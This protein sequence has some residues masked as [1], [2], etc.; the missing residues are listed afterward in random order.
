MESSNWETNVVPQFWLNMEPTRKRKEE[1]DVN[2][3]SMTSI[4]P[5][6]ISDWYYSSSPSSR[7]HSRVMHT[8]DKWTRWTTDSR[9][10]FGFFSSFTH[11]VNDDKLAKSNVK[12]NE[13]ENECDGENDND[14]RMCRCL[15]VFFSTWNCPDRRKQRRKMLI[16]IDNVFE[17]ETQRKKE[18]NN[19]W[20]VCQQDE[21]RV[22]LEL[23]FC[24]QKAYTHT[25]RIIVEL[26]RMRSERKSA[27][28]HLF[29][30]LI[31]NNVEKRRKN[32]S[33]IINNDDVKII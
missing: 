5:Q 27:R 11:C 3:C 25:C 1:K 14:D 12:E 8:F 19:Q 29:F 24:C 26:T 32:F 7:S 17:V 18:R 15:I 13:N 10:V 21:R 16:I 31:R 30:S 20:H 2:T 28:I 22:K 9:N 33:L 6:H 4:D 23:F